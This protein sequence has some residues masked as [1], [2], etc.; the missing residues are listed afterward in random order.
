MNHVLD[1]SGNMLQ[2]DTVVYREHV[3]FIMIIK[4]SPNSA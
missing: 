2:A 4:S 3:A 1:V